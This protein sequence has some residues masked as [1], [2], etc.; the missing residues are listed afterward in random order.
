M[1]GLRVLAKRRAFG[2]VTAWAVLTVVFLAFTT[3]RDWVA[4]SIAGGI[5]FG[6]GPDANRAEV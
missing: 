4:D 2:L 6:A 1:R 3:T 5:A